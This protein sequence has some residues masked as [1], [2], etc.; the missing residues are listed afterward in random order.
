MQ[1][2]QKNWISFFSDFTIYLLTH[3]FYREGINAYAHIGTDR[4]HFRIFQHELL[5]YSPITS[6]TLVTLFISVL[7]KLRGRNSEKIM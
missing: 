1:I 4:S 3:I 6:S 7:L 5:I 2:K